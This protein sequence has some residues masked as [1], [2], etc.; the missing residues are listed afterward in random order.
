MA[1]NS[2]CGKQ[3]FL[4]WETEW[5]TFDE[6]IQGYISQFLIMGSFNYLH[7]NE[8]NTIHNILQG[9]SMRIHN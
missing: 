4:P 2:H 3:N 9:V 1:T 6:N 5:E 8:I 7:F